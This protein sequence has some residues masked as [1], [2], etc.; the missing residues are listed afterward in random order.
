MSNAI[1]SSGA[2]PPKKLF[3]VATATSAA[4]ANT[5]APGAAFRL[6]EVR[7]KI[8]TAG[9]TSEAFTITMDAG[10][11]AAY[12]ALLLTQ[13]TKVPAITDLVVPFGDGYEFEVDDELDAAWPNTENR[14][15][16]LTW[17]YEYV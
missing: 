16:G 13:N 6:L 3:Q 10:D 1:S 15:Y 5:L 12:D 11:G 7:L 17:V 9:T 4:I 2:K 14:T 8:N